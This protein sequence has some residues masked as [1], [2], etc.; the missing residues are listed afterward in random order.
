[1]CQQA[2]SQA[3]AGLTDVCAQVSDGWS[4]GPHTEEITMTQLLYNIPL[5][6]LFFALWVGF[7]VWLVLRHPDTG[8]ETVQTA[9]I[10]DLT[11]QDDDSGYED[12]A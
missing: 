10:T 4:N 6:I 7:P 3:V 5:M 2:D 9:A 12:A 8:P 1:V 11:Q